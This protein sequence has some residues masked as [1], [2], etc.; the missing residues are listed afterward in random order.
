MIHHIQVNDYC[1]NWKGI[2]LCY[3]GGCGFG[4]GA[5]G[6]IGWP[7]RARLIELGENGTISTYK[8]LDYFLG[9][10]AIKDREQIWPEVPPPPIKSCSACVAKKRV[11]CYNDNTCFAHGDSNDTKPGS[12]P[13]SAFCASDAACDCTSCLDKKCQPKQDS[14]GGWHN[15][16]L[17]TTDYTP[18]TWRPAH[19]HEHPGDHEDDHEDDHEHDHER[20]HHDHDHRH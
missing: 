6:K 17:R 8:R 20:D 19:D 15:W 5:Y 4:H 3:G 18:S 10:L 12:C 16:Q 7:R 2:D 1:T 11:W 13:G 9:N 14:N